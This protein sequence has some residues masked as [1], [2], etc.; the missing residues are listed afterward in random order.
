MPLSDNCFWIAT[1]DTLLSEDVHYAGRG[2]L[3]WSVMRPWRHCACLIQL[4]VCHSWYVTFHIK[5]V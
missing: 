5:K 4:L 2:T 1:A 3:F